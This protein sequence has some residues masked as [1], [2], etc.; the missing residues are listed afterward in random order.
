MKKVSAINDPMKS[1]SECR[2]VWHKATLLVDPYR[3]GGYSYYL[4]FP[5]Y[6][7]DKQICPR[8]EEVE[9]ECYA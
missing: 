8:C 9:H 2:I 6:G 1:C 7:L 3:N 4:D 5:H